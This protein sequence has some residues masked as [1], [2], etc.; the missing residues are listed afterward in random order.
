MERK[1]RKKKL[2]TDDNISR[3]VVQLGKDSSCVVSLYSFIFY[4]VTASYYMVAPIHSDVNVLGMR[5]TTETIF[6]SLRPQ[7]RIWHGLYA[8]NVI[9]LLFDYYMCVCLFDSFLALEHSCGP[10]SPF[11]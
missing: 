11:C 9:Y 10:K 8:H 4:S 7:K 2:Y 5:S 3:F 6:C 1:H